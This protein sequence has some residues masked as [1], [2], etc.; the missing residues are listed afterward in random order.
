MSDE[1]FD[2]TGKSTEWLYNLRGK[3]DMF[4]QA[5][6]REKV[7]ASIDRELEKRDE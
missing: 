6:V 7:S 1:L 5:A 2:Y 3:L 4:A